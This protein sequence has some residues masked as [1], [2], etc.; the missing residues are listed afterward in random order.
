MGYIQKNLPK[1]D[2][3]NIQSWPKYITSGFEIQNTQLFISNEVV[4]AFI[5]VIN[6]IKI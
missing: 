4:E 5:F 6:L 1:I 3:T 2:I